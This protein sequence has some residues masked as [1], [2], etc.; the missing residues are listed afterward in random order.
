MTSSRHFRWLFIAAFLTMLPGSSAFAHQ[1]IAWGD[2]APGL[3]VFT[4]AVAAL[5]LL[6]VLA[7]RLPARISGPRY[8]SVLYAVSVA[9]GA[10]G[11]TVFANIAVIRHDV[12]LDLTREAVN[13]PPPQFQSVVAGLDAELSLLYFYNGADAN[14]LKAKEL[15]TVAARQ[16]PLL[17]FRAVDLDKDPATTRAF[18]VRAYNTA[19]VTAGDRRVAVENTADLAQIAFAA[20]RVLKKETDVVCMVSGH[21]ESVGEAHPHFTHVESLEGHD[22]PGANDVLEGAADGLDR[23]NVALGSLGYSVRTILLA[24][25]T[26]I[27]ADCRV[28][29]EIG[30]R[31]EYAPGEARLLS[32][33]L[34]R[35]GRVLAM[36]DPVFPLGDEFAGLLHD[37]GLS[38]DQATVID[39]L[40]HHGTDEEKVAVPYYPPHPIT[41]RIALTIFPHARPITVAAPPDGVSTA[42][43][44]TSSKD[45]YLRPLS[46][47][48]AGDANAPRGPA[49]LA[50]ALEGRW[51]RPEAEPGSRF[52]LVVVGSS[53]FAGN[54]YF[55]YVSNGDLAVGMIRWVADDEARPAAKP[56]SFSLEQITLTPSQMRNIF[57]AVEILLPFSVLAFGGLVMWRRR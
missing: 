30:P 50:V 40:N 53:N 24:T 4:A 46:R 48:Q 33:F 5:L 39:P 7:L 8:K 19:V 6:F 1:D 49:V 20:L 42:I 2:K 41:R 54:S 36:I 9:S 55:P 23:L 11:L 21:G 15:L 47:L 32:D 31:R 52:R 38:L 3:A 44:A 18:G 45:S 56:Q 14:A 51:P 22:R 29:A 17:R 43:L 28:V 25:L 34:A 10:V 16:Y 13:S 12:H 27:P 37:V 26:A 57:V 35:G